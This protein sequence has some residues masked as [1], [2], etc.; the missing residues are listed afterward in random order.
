MIGLFCKRTLQKRRY[1]AKETYNLSILLTIATP[2][3]YIYMYVYFHVYIHI[4]IYIYCYLYDCLYLQ[5]Q[6]SI[7]WDKCLYL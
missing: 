2:Y 7:S 4:Y 3:V 1:S 5:E 6:M